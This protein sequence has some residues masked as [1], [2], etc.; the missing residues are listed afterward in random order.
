[1]WNN[2]LEEWMY[3]KID[4]YTNHGYEFGKASGMAPRARQADVQNGR[5]IDSLY[6]SR[7][8]TKRLNNFFQDCC[9]Q[10]SLPAF[11]RLCC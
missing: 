1:M 5:F 11:W 6:S 4:P 3:N 8:E 2:P 9:L 10:G 7:S